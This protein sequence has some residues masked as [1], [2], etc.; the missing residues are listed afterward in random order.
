[1]RRLLRDIREARGAKLRK[2]VEVLEGG[3][4]V[5]LDGVAGLEVA[6]QGRFI[7][8]VVDG[9]RLPSILEVGGVSLDLSFWSVILADVS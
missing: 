6:E 5:V 3:R 1:M 8:G 7:R 2:G 4:V 9:L